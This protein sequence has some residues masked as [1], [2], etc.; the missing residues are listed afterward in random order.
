M[1]EKIVYSNHC[2]FNFRVDFSFVAF[3]DAEVIIIC[4]S[5][6][7]SCVKLRVYWIKPIR[8]N[9]VDWLIGGKMKEIK[10]GFS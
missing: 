6:R 9:C 8:M 2:K 7:N 5:E 3:T 4:K 1:Y 10:A